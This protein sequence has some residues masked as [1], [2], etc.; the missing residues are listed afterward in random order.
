VP[1]ADPIITLRMVAMDGP[2]LVANAIG[3]VL[4]GTAG[5]AMPDEPT[6]WAAAAAISGTWAI[7]S[8]AGRHARF[9]G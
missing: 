2:I 1:N 8:P 6:S 7:S 3:S 4:G 5:I 9:I